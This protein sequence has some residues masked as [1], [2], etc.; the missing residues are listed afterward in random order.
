MPLS[1]KDIERIMSLGYKVHEFVRVEA[2]GIPRLKNINGHCVFLD[3]DTGRCRIYPWR[4]LGCKLYPLIYV[5]GV[6]LSFDEYCPLV[7]FLT[8]EEKNFI[9]KKLGKHLLRLIE[10]IYGLEY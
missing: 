9:V 2:D 7:K 4:P 3:E 1:R 10:E 5:D 6:G 8:N